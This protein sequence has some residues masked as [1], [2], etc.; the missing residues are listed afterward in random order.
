MQ[1]KLIALAVV[2]A[3]SAPAFADVTAY[4]VIDAAVVNVSA[5]G[6][7]SDMQAISGGLATSRFGVKSVED[8]NN[9]MKAVVVL[10]YGLNTKSTRPLVWMLPA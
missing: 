9:G 3:F 2:A 6:E 1:K 8:L 5:S 7:K 10:E 4:G